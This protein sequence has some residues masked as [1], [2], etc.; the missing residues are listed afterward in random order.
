MEQDTTNPI[1]VQGCTRA[2]AYL[3]LFGAVL[4]F[5]YDLG[6]QR[7]YVEAN[8]EAWARD[9]R[10]AI[11]NTQLVAQLNELRASSPDDVPPAWCDDP[12]DESLRLARAP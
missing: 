12:P 8:N 7:G 2:A 9:D 4:A 3:L 11:E 5:T 10:A 6:R 1:T